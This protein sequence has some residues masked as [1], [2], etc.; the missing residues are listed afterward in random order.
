MA[1]PSQ[2]GCDVRDLYVIHRVLR[3]L[4]GRAPA[5]I[6]SCG[7]DPDRHALIDA[8]IEEITVVLHRHHHG[9]D[10]TLWDRLA[11]RRPACALHVEMMRAQHADIAVHLD[12][13]ADAHARW[14]ADRSGAQTELVNALA[15]VHESLAAHLA[16][17]EPFVTGNAP[18]LLTQK[19]WDELRDHGIAGIPKDR[20]LVQLGYML[21]S[22]DSEA[23]RTEFWRA[24]PVIARVM[25]R[26]FGAR[27]ISKEL[28]ALYGD[29]A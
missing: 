21:R 14:K 16:R 20:M 18:E 13:V 23:E 10:I 4:F 9:E 27:S 3:A 7:A 1:L 24:L 11:E 19:E 2:V 26:L 8:H 28:T 6:A 17:E 22:F 15:A 5:L 29:D 12:R 25:Y